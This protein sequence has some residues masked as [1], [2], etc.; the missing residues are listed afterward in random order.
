MSG[1]F[2]CPGPAGPIEVALAEPAEPPR[3]I[4][5]L[6]HPHPQH[7]GTMDNKVVQTLAKAAVDVG[8]LAVR[9]NF[10][11][12]GQSAGHFDH[13]VGETEDAQAVLDWVRARH[14]GLPLI[15]GGFSFGAYVQT[16]LLPRS[17]P[18]ALVLVGPAVSRFEL[19]ALPDRVAEGTLV[20]HG[21]A[22][23]V[24]P[25]AA[26][27]DWARPQSLPVTVFPGVGHFFHG[28]LVRLRQVVRTALL[29]RL[30]APGA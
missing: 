4:A 10:R 2:T 28:Q 11:G 13:G 22:D 18:Q 7:G 6:C 30:S 15:A 27:L 5:L 12:V 26:V 1:H 14:R 3:A 9:F 20:V 17:E 19:G 25:L 8:A 24:V 29:A 21:E 16:R 23:E